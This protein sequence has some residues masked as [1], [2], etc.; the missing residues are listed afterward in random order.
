[1][2]VLNIKFDCKEIISPPFM[3]HIFNLKR[4]HDNYPDPKMRNFKLL[5]VVF[6]ENL[7]FNKQ[8]QSLCV[9]LTRAIYCL[10][11]VTHF[12]P[13]NPSKLF[14]FFYSI[15]LALLPHSFILHCPNKSGKH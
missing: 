7:T 11:R 2:Q 10:R 3:T 1:M 9:K 14:T 12:A 15:P 8:A 5:G 13:S 4:I 6:D